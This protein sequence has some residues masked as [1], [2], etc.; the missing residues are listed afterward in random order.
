VS[1]S[2]LQESFHLFRVLCE[3]AYLGP[4]ADRVSGLLQLLS[5]ELSSPFELLMAAFIQC[6][7]ER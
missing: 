7:T 4:N 2:C 5:R 1:L 6:G 3:D